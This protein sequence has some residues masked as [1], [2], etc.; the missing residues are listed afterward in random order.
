MDIVSWIVIGGLVVIAALAV[1]LLKWLGH[2]RSLLNQLEAGDAR[3]VREAQEGYKQ[4]KYDEPGSRGPI[5][6][7]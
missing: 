2:R 5:A 4:A 3:E 7:F 1:G 6:P